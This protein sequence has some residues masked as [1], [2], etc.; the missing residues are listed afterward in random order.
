MPMRKKLVYLFQDAIYESQDLLSDVLAEKVIDRY[1]E[2]VHSDFIAEESYEYENM[3]LE[4]ED[5][6]YYYWEKGNTI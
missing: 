5:I 2:I 1:P 3:W 6:D 4:V